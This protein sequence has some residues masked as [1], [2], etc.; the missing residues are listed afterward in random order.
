[1][2][3][4]RWRL[5]CRHQLLLWDA[6]CPGSGR[7]LSLLLRACSQT[8]GACSQT[9]GICRTS[10]WL[11]YDCPLSFYLGVLDLDLSVP[12][13]VWSVSDTASH[14]LLPQALHL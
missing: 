11:P 9:K 4:G 14:H 5:H 2:S 12:P 3:S 13:D 1:M 6:G 10:S 8:K 7:A